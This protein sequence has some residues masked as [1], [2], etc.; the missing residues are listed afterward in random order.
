MSVCEL[1]CGAGIPGLIAARS[2]QVRRVSSLRSLLSHSELRLIRS[3]SLFRLA[4]QVVLTDYADA[5]LID[6]LKSNIELAYESDD[7]TKEKLVA[8]G[9]TWGEEDS[10]ARII[11]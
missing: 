11:E 7:L 6:N 5:L 4:I 9:H 8:F 2:R 1:G 3:F 10:L